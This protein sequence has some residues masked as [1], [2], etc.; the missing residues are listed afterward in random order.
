MDLDASQSLDDQRDE[1]L[2]EQYRVG[3]Q[4]AYRILVERYQQ[5]L[6]H[7]LARFV[8]DA[9]IAEDLFQE[10][11]LQVHL[12]IDSF[13]TSRRF[14]PWLFTI[15]ANKARDYLRKIKQRAMVPMSGTMM[16]RL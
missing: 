6:Y 14:R 2:V 3:N 15:A 4:Q 16:Q 8:S 1:L 10:A 7:F 9:A 13:D 11:F 5:E 12:S